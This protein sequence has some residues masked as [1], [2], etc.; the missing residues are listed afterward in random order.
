MLCGGTPEGEK[1]EEVSE[2][3]MKSGRLHELAREV[4]FD[5]LATTILRK[6]ECSRIITSIDETSKTITVQFPDLS[7]WIVKVPKRKVAWTVGSHNY[8][9]MKAGLVPPSKEFEECE[10]PDFCSSCGRAR[11]VYHEKRAK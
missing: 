7:E 9:R 10:N 3:D 8:W 6:V 1:E 4:P 11:R 2:A 5:E